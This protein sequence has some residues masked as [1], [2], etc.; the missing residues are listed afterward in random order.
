MIISR[1]G[2][3]HRLT[4]FHTSFQFVSKAKNL[5]SSAKRDYWYGVER[6]QVMHLCER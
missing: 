3:A 2:A 5:A 6:I 4:D 1:L